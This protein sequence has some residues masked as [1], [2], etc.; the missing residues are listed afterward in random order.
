MRTDLPEARLAER[1]PI[2]GSKTI[3]SLQNFLRIEVTWSEQVFPSGT[4]VVR[5]SAAWSK[6]AWPP[7]AWTEFRVIAIRTVLIFASRR[8]TGWTGVTFSSRS[9]RNSSSQI[10]SAAE[11]IAET[12]VMT[13][14][15]VS[16]SWFGTVACKHKDNAHFVIQEEI[17]YFWTVKEAKGMK[18]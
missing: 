6:F 5:S 1:S 11:L 7:A 14:T 4:E 16:A 8:S 10:V 12:R 3:E 13:I 18:G 9:Y 2:S 17:G 15:V